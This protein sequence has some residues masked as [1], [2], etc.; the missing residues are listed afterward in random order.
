MIAFMASA[1]IATESN[2]QEVSNHSLSKA[3]LYNLMMGDIAL[4]RQQYE[5]ALGYYMQEINHIDDS[6]IV[7]KAI[8]IAQFLKRYPDMLK[9]AQALTLLTPDD[10]ASYQYLSLS[11]S[12]NLETVKSLEA[13][14]K[15]LNLG[16]ET[17]FTQIVYLLP[18]DHPSNGY[19][20]NELIQ[21]S[22]LNPKN[23]DIALSLA[24]LHDRLRKSEE[25][26][27][28]T[29]NALRYGHANTRVVE[30]SISLFARNNA[31]DKV[32]KTYEIA[33]RNNPANDKLRR[34]YANFAMRY[35]PSIAKQQYNILLGKYPED[36]Q[37]LVQLALLYLEEGNYKPAEEI[38]KNLIQLQ[39]RTSL[40]YFYLGLIEQERGNHDKA[41][42]HLRKVTSTKEKQKAFEHIVYIHVDQK[43]FELAENLIIEQ[44]EKT[45]DSTSL[46]GLHSMLADT[47]SQQGKH[48]EAYKLLTK[49][50]KNNPD[51][52]A[53]RYNRA[54][55]LAESDNT[56]SEMESDLRHIISIK[57]DNAYAL[58]A[59]GYTLADRTSRYTEALELIKQAHKLLPDDPSVLDSLGWVLFRMGR[60]Q[61][62]VVHLQNAVRQLPD[63]EVAAH[64]GEV[65]WSLGKEADAKKV[66]KKALETS[67]RH[68]K[69]LETIKRLNVSL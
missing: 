43:N 1:A 16:G 51:S 41:L 24:L 5:Q 33:L 59:L 31:E 3:T 47:Y 20:L 17:D 19:F 36:D 4:S 25:V 58:N 11:H 65:L 54:M 45:T 53:L 69:L 13:M 66:F 68:S 39:K 42:T 6:L 22:V 30:I 15:A 63:A 23:F 57:P 14:K 46:E 28:Y 29:E 12:Y 34:S 18:Q 44:I 50:L 61:E 38:L 2:T 60:A 64:L 62:A 26:I 48:E 21:L 37:V 9:A 55:M 7:L 10:P 27:F 40:S 49:L 32:L 52:I 8:D 35:D 56:L 67:P